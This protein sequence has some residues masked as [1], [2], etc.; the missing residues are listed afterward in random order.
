VNRQNQHLLHQKIDY[1]LSI[2]EK[3]RG[4]WLRASPTKKQQLTT[5][6]NKTNVYYEDA[7]YAA[8]H[9]H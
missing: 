1:E 2:V 3:K 6:E 4:K 8:R 5:A 9:F 7:G